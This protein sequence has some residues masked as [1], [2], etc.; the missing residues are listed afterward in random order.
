MEMEYCPQQGPGGRP[1]RIVGQGVS[2]HGTWRRA[3]GARPC[4][5]FRW[6]RSSLW[7]FAGSASGTAAVYRWSQRRVGAEWAL[8]SFGLSACGEAPA[9]PPLVRC[10]EEVPLAPRLQRGLEVIRRPAVI[11]KL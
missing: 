8:R 3:D 10:C 9:T 4:S 1:A 2:S 6:T 11:A 5:P 7:T